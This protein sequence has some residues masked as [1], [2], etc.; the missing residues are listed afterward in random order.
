MAGFPQAWRQGREWQEV[1]SPEVQERGISMIKIAVTMIFESEA[2][3]TNEQ[4]TI[5]RNLVDDYQ[6]EIGEAVG[7]EEI[8]WAIESEPMIE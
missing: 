3:L 6:C 4:R 2:T 1:Q 8:E 5:L 7:M